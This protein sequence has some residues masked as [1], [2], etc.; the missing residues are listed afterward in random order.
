[1]SGDHKRVNERGLRSSNKQKVI[2]EARIEVVT[3]LS[4]VARPSTRYTRHLDTLLV[5]GG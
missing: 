5:W 1:M 4:R 3:G 2:L